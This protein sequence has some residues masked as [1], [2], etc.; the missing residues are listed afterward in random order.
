MQISPEKGDVYMENVIKSITQHP[1]IQICWM[2][3]DMEA[4]ARRWVEI[5][6]AGPFFLIPH[7]T[8]GGENVTYKGQPSTLD[9]SSAI[10]QWGTIQI[11][12]FEQHCDSPAGMRELIAPGQVHH[13]TW[14]VED[15]DSEFKRL[16]DMGFSN[17]WTAQM[18][19]DGKRI[20]WF[21]ATAVLGTLI[22]VYEDSNAIRGFYRKI[23]KA[24]EGWK[25]EN[26]IRRFEELKFV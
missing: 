22:E 18:K 4:A 26:P 10:G 19:K 14:M 8:D 21:D 15:F 12:L 11:E 2:V 3:D 23:A 1:I 13:M 7:I 6:G 20:G 16:E 25:G 9:Q 17:V 24:A 5:M